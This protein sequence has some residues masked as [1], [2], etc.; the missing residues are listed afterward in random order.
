MNLFL[1]VVVILSLAE[2]SQEHSDLSSALAQIRDITAAVDLTVYKYERSQELQEV[3]AR[4]ETKS[5]AKLK[6][7]KVFRKQ[8]LH[9]KHRE[10]QHKGLVYWKT[11][12]G[13]LKDT[14]ALLL[15]DVLVFLQEKDQ[16]FIFASVDQKPPVIPLQKLIV[17]EVANEEKGMF[18]ISASSLGPEMYE[19]HTTT[20]EER[21]AWMRHIRQAVERCEEEEERCA[22]TEEARVFRLISEKLFGQD[23]RICHS[24]EEKLHLYAELTELTLRPSEPVSH[25][26]LL[27]QPAQ[28]IDSETPHQAASLL[29]DALREGETAAASATAHTNVTIHD[30]IIDPSLSL[31]KSVTLQD[32]YYEVHKLLLQERERPALRSFAS[33]QS[34]LVCS[35]RRL[36]VVKTSAGEHMTSRPLT[37]NTEQENLLEH[38]EQQCLLEAERLRCEREVLEA[39]LLE[40]Q[41]NLDRLKE[42]QKGVERE[43]EKI[44]VQQRLLQGWRHSRQSSL[45]VSI[46]LDGYKV[47]INKTETV[48]HHPSFIYSCFQSSY[49]FNSLNTL[50]SQSPLYGTNHSC[51]RAPAEP[52]LPFS[53]GGGVS[54]QTQR[55]NSSKT[56]R[57]QTL[58]FSLKHD[59]SFVFILLE[60]LNLLQDAQSSS[61]WR[62]EVTSHRLTKEHNSPS[63][64]PLLPPQAYL[65]LEGQTREEVGEENIVYL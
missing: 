24:L 21:N 31:Q 19:V 3:L 20:K 54:A 41:Q 23:Q 42:G 46:P 30:L 16:R 51:P 61:F 47:T 14:L 5:F 22:E 1:P 53:G 52:V 59:L 25:R 15:T 29:T 13:R 64:M 2:G 34:S 7:G 17:R 11:A 8:D 45:P 38:R 48:V 32:S 44:Q 36:S 12:T 60:D 40:Y 55:S 33:L 56:N 18:L 39:Q 9:S 62:S 6:N 35:S 63:L 50:L 27:V 37:C 26:H 43:K 10:L 4:L 28:Y 57:D 65:S 58:P 49:L